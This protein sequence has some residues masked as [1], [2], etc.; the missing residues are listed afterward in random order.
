MFGFPWAFFCG[1]FWS[2]DAMPSENRRGTTKSMHESTTILVICRAILSKNTTIDCWGCQIRR[3]SWL[4]RNVSSENLQSETLAPSTPTV[5]V[6][7]LSSLDDV[8]A[9]PSS[10]FGFFGSFG[11][12]L[13]RKID[14][15]QQNQC[16]NFTAWAH[17]EFQVRGRSHVPVNTVE[18]FH[19]ISL[20]LGLGLACHDERPSQANPSLWLSPPTFASRG[21][22]LSLSL[23][24][25]QAHQLA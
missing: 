17:S 22:P 14:V 6:G 24:T 5:E 13:L 20:L 16:T 9:F 19:T 7:T 15:D 4:R 3:P 25:M 8:F 1:F 21:Q 10:F 11:A 2:F 23:G 18:E 12:V